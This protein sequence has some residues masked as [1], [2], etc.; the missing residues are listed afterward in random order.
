MG[1]FL[2][3]CPPATVRAPRKEKVVRPHG[4]ENVAA[5]V[6]F[7]KGLY[8]TTH[9]SEHGFW[10]GLRSHAAYPY[11]EC[12][13]VIVLSYL[14]SS[15]NARIRCLPHRSPTLIG[16]TLH[17]R[18]WCRCLPCMSDIHPQPCPAS[19][20]HIAKSRRTTHHDGRQDD[21]P[22]TSPRLPWRSHGRRAAGEISDPGP[23]LV[24]GVAYH[25]PSAGHVGTV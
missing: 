25:G 9:A 14:P 21:S 7:G 3:T 5:C 1:V 20:P 16:G 12:I 17:P 10:V 13:P 6:H 22:L 8:V 24:S 15:L 4:C 11:R 18:R 2:G 23:C 19:S